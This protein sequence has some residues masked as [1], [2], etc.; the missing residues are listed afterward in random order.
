MRDGSTQ[1]TAKLLPFG[2]G[3]HGVFAFIETV[4]RLSTRPRAQGNERLNTQ[5]LMLNTMIQSAA[6]VG[7]TKNKNH[8]K[9]GCCHSAKRYVDGRSRLRASLDCS[10]V[11]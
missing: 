5:R 2:G 11:S 10:R 7:I 3:A 4:V 8:E 1:A 6:M 9:T